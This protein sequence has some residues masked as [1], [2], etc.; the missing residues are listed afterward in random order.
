MKQDQHPL[1]Q[2][3]S[4]EQVAAVV[5]HFYDRVRADTQLAPHFDAIEDWPRHE[6]FITD[7]W[8][9]AMGGKVA[10][11]RPGAM[12]KGHQ[13]LGITPA[14]MARWLTLFGESIEALLPADEAQR[15]QTIARGI[16]A[17][18]GEHGLVEKSD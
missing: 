2:S 13:G 12:V 4:R 10:T 3:V 17:V 6:A 9:G 8:W 11:P 14:A 5:H 16:A 7:F 1:C 15:W 18:M